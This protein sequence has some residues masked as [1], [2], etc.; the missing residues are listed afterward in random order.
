MLW[1]CF[2]WFNLYRP[3]WAARLRQSRS[4][5][6]HSCSNKKAAKVKFKIGN[7]IRGPTV[8]TF[9]ILHNKAGAADSRT[10]Y[11]V[12]N[13]EFRPLQLFC[14]KRDLAEETTAA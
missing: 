3:R 9:S 12:T 2:A 5:T 11:G 8:Y 13:F 7:T 4:V 14:W 10:L 1:K 6:R